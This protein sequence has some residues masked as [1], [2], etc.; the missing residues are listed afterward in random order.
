MSRLIRKSVLVSALILA[1]MLY[2]TPAA[3]ACGG[4]G[5][6]GGGGGDS[7]SEDD[8]AVS[9]SIGGAPSD[10]DPG[11]SGTSSSPSQGDPSASPDTVH[12]AGWQ[13]DRADIDAQMEEEKMTENI[14]SLINFMD[15]NS[16][17]DAVDKEIQ[18]LALQT[19]TA[20]YLHV[21]LTRPDATH[22]E[23]MLAAVT[24]CNFRASF[25]N[26]NSY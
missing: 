3:F 5:G 25:I 21:R 11:A 4:G 24:I 19:I 20:T 18:E 1:V 14:Q 10:I 23:A 22:Q 15:E 7:K 16:G 26:D 17:A 8:S 2:V 13:V 9:V 12:I 6:G